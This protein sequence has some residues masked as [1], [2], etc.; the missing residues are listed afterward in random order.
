MKNIYTLIVFLFTPFILN[1]SELDSLMNVLKTDINKR[2]AYDAQK[3]NRLENFTKLIKE[4]NLQGEELFYINNQL[5][6]EY[7]AYSYDSTQ[8]YIKQ[9][10]QLAESINSS[11]LIDYSRLRLTNILASSGRY[12]EAIEM[13]NKVNAANFED[14]QLI[15]Y[16]QDN[17]KIFTDLSVYSPL[18]DN[19]QKYAAIAQNY[20]DSLIP[21]LG[22]DSE[23]LLSI[24]EKEYRD[25]REL[26]KCMQ[27]NDI[28]LSKAE[29]GSRRYS[30]IT[31][32]RSLIYQLQNNTAQRKKYL[33]LS[34]I[35][36]IRSAIKDNASLTELALIL[37]KEGEVEL[38]YNF[39]KVAYDD[40]SFYNSR[41]RFTL[42][43]NILPVINQAYYIRG[44]EQRAKM[45][46][47][48]IIISFLSLLFILSLFIGYLQL[49]TL[50]KA[51]AKQ[52]ESNLYQKQLNKDL[53][54]IN[55]QLQEV[56]DD[57]KEANLVKEYYIANFL[58][59]CSNYIDKLDSYNKNVYKQITN[60]KVQALLASSKS[61][62]LLA[63]EVKE[64]YH[65]FDSTFL[66]IFPHFVE[67][68]NALLNEEDQIILKNKEALTTEL[69]VFA[70]IRL[71]IKDSS[72][73]AKLLRYSVNTIYNY[74]AKLKNM[75]KGDRD[76]FEEMVMKIDATHVS[77][78]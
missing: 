25:K 1:A 64:F 20:T 47:F 34:A 51:Q 50:R 37:H 5:I 32:E 36:D 65:N 23:E 27:I 10:L 52:H 53:Q 21:L 71:G 9:N 58:T 16:Y 39:I 54:Q 57:L 46:K 14:E 8:H 4:R 49:R 30:L 44:E 2:P 61:N 70:L 29:M 68:I 15:D 45:Q 38:A 67:A 18:N 60:Q 63:A 78:D 42:I 35:S 62:K 33:I 76:S 22:G 31:F 73:I 75:A 11:K 40:A 48:L 43:S 6:K 74:R 19:Y 12:Y 56:N 24:K 59:I 72:R 41:L 26:E 55:I 77:M 7:E 28:R 17:I 66:H 3:E 69:R 13:L